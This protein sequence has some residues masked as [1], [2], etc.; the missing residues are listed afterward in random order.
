MSI[1]ANNIPGGLFNSLAIDSV[2]NYVYS[3]ETGPGDVN[4]YK[5]DSNGLVTIF[6]I[7]TDPSEPIWI[8]NIVFD[9]LGFS[10]GGFL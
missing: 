6:S 1:F 7:I 2:N 5:I 3:N 8:S 9:S 4:I 10:N